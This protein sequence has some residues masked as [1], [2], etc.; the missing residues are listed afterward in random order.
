L[1]RAE[2]CHYIGHLEGEPTAC[3][4]LTGCPG[5]DDLDIT[6]MSE[7]SNHAM[8]Q[9]LK[10]GSV[11]AIE[12]P[13]KNA[14]PEFPTF[15]R[16]EIPDDWTDEEDD[17]EIL[18][19]EE[20]AAEFKAAA[21]VSGSVQA[22]NVLTIQAGYDD[23]WLQKTGG[24]SEAKT[25]IH[26]IMPHVQ[27]LYCHA[28]LGTVIKI[29][30]KNDIKHFAGRDL[31]ASGAMLQSMFDTTKN[32]LGDAD[33]MLYMAYDPPCQ[34]PCS[35][36]AGIAYTGV[37]CIHPV[38]NKVKQSICEWATTHAATA[39]TVA[40]EVGHNLGMKHDFDAAHAAA[41]CDKTGVM[42]YG[43]PVNKWSTCSASDFKN[44][45]LANKDSWCMPATANACGNVIPIPTTTTT[46]TEAP[47]TC[48]DKWSKKQECDSL[49]QGWCQMGGC[50]CCLC[51][52]SCSCRCSAGK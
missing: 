32:N 1:N 52:N 46:T 51:G 50:N 42:S 35:Y 25:Y 48:E 33:L 19:P 26:T 4:G 14:R 17:D 40:H 27:A 49:N 20:E 6:I 30:L 44:H 34:A 18:N 24:H 41:G 23:S 3:I 10:D 29:E 5:S 16:E 12:S 45:Y 39:H 7:H 13:L 43:D 37:A 47:K 8:F 31:S 9:W 28:S 36:T 11:K 38:N 22:S 21:M 15:E 2:A